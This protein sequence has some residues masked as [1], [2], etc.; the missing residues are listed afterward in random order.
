LALI[1][2][3]IVFG[4]GLLGDSAGFVAVAVRRAGSA[5]PA[6][7]DAAHDMLAMFALFFGI[8]L[9]F[10]ALISGVL[11]ALA[12]RWGLFRYPWVMLKQVLIVS[13]ILVGALVLRPLLWGDDPGDTALI[14]GGS[15]DVLALLTATTL[16]VVKPVR[17]YQSA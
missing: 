12:T 17:Q 16:G 13:V 3:H 5:D 11:L 8:P 2:A 14:L 10:L 4:V 1:T 15:W 9:S 7:R 6:F